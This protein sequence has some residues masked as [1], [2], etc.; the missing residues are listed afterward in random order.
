M[1][2]RVVLTLLAACVIGPL[3]ALAGVGG[4]VDRA[5]PL[6]RLAR[7]G[8]L[9]EAGFVLTRREGQA[10]ALDTTANGKG[11]EI[12]PV[13]VQN[14]AGQDV[15]HDIPFAFAFLTFHPDGEWMTGR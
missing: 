7:S 9:R 2:C 5:W 4:V 3:P 6:I 13:R 15:V 1:R 12:G 8:L 10:P 11:R 14:A